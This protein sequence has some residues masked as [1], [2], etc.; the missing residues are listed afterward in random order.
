[1]TVKLEHA[2]L[3]LVVERGIMLKSEY[4]GEV[5]CHKRNHP[6]M[7]TGMTFVDGSCDPCPDCPS[8]STAGSGVV[9]VRDQLRDT[10]EF[11]EEDPDGYDYKHCTC[12]NSFRYHT[13]TDKCK[14]ISGCD[15][16]CMKKLAAQR[17]LKDV[18]IQGI[19]ASLLGRVQTTPRAELYAILFAIVFDV[20]PQTV[21]CD[22]WNH[23]LKLWELATV[24]SSVLNPMTPN[25][26]LWRKVVAAIAGRRGLRKDGQRQLWIT[27]QPSHL[28]AHKQSTTEQRN[29]RRA[30]E[31]ADHFANAG[32]LLHAPTHN[33]VSRTMYLYRVART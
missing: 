29:L 10:R 32:R 8:M 25:L 14:E 2:P 1:M 9:C 27:W 19:A 6:R 5:E 17:R 13:C 12:M 20:S 7:I 24:V 4:I 11:G 33:A 22:H 23:V 31:T 15:Q 28:R 16:V 26:D 18:P 3:H 21:A 30:N